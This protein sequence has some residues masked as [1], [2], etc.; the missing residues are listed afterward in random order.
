ML[1]KI[2]PV[3]KNDSEIG[4]CNLSVF[5]FCCA[6]F[7][8]DHWLTNIGQTDKK[9]HCLFHTLHVCTQAWYGTMH[10]ML[11]SLVLNNWNCRWHNHLNPEIRKDAWTPEEERALINAHRVYG[12][13]W[14]E[15]AKALPG[16]YLTAYFPLENS[17]FHSFSLYE[18][19]LLL[20]VDLVNDVELLIIVILQFFST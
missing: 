17:L 14:A 8:C 16:R 20:S 5:L 11:T 3:W 15:I 7:I 10:N 19:T 9:S 4:P 18:I 1:R 13:K 6:P 2:G 12:N